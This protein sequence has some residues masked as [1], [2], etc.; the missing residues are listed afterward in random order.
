MRP[1]GATDSAFPLSEVEIRLHEGIRVDEPSIDVVDGVVHI[2]VGVT[3]DP[4]KRV[5]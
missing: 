3:D 4:G 1:V 5:V 2:D